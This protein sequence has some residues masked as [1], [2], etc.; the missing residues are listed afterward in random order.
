MFERRSS[1]IGFACGVFAMI[2]AVVLSWVMDGKVGLPFYTAIAGMIVVGSMHWIG[3][4][5]GAD[6]QYDEC[7]KKQKVE[8]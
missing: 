1:K 6:I 8:E 3:L 5:V 2:F 4:I 7:K